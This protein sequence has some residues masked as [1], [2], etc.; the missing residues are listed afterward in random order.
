MPQPEIKD[1]SNVTSFY[2]FAAVYKGI[3]IGCDINFIKI[4]YIKYTYYHTPS[5]ITATSIRSITCQALLLVL[6]IN[7]L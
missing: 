1:N 2:S 4:S 5:R 6:S 7:K 3:R